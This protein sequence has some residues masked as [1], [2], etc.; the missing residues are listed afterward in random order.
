MQGFLSSWEI[1]CDQ[2]IF[3]PVWAKKSEF[4]LRIWIKWW[5]KSQRSEKKNEKYE[6]SNAMPVVYQNFKK[7]C[8]IEKKKYYL[9]GTFFLLGTF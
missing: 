9:L 2:R 4:V 6:H 3:F 8:H 7:R 1:L 5:A